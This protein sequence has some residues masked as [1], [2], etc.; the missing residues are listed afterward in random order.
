M[1]EVVRQFLSGRG[2]THPSA[3]RSG[4]AGSARTTVPSPHPYL[5]LKMDERRRDRAPL[6]HECGHGIPRTV[7]AQGIFQRDTP[8]TL[9]ETASVVRRDRHFRRLMDQATDRPI[10]A[11]CWPEHSRARFALCSASRHVEV[12]ERSHTHPSHRGESRS[13][14]SASSGTRPSMRCWATS[15]R[16]A[17]DTVSW[18][19]L[20]APLHPHPW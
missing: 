10:A 2:S 1:A 17:M 8:L 15:V 13:D 4:G 12:E 18:W 6:A 20:R 11:R 7:A 9:A 5:L 19:S 16:R 14:R 3:T